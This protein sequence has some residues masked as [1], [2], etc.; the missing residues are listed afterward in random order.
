MSLC[1][2]VTQHQHHKQ[3]RFDYSLHNQTD[4]TDLLLENVLSTK[5]LGI[6]STDK[7][8]GVSRFQKFLLKQMS[9]ML[10]FLHRKMTF[11]PRS[12]KEVP[13]KTFDWTKLENAASIWSPY[14]KI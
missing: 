14:S 10:C 8:I 5:Y 12:T 9:K 2:R 13:Y 6:T 4:H 3:I 1:E 7:W 11:A